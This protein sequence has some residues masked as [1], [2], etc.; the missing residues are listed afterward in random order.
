MSTSSCYP[1]S[2]GSVRSHGGYAVAVVHAL[3]TG[4]NGLIGLWL[5]DREIRVPRGDLGARVHT[6]WILK[7]SE[8]TRYFAGYVVVPGVKTVSA[9]FKRDLEG[10]AWWPEL[11]MTPK[12]LEALQYLED[13]L[14]GDTGSFPLWFKGNPKRVAKAFIRKLHR[15]GHDL[16]AMN[17]KDFKERYANRTGRPRR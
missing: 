12:E 13:P 10:C 8:G 15:A 9:R 1:L 14:C 2:R 11:P 3:C 16:A 5:W 6:L 4:S 7:A 17:P